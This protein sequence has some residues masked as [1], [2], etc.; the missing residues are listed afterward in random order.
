MLGRGCRHY[1]THTLRS[2]ARRCCKKGLPCIPW[3]SFQAF[4]HPTGRDRGH[5]TP[6]SVDWGSG[7]VCRV[8][9]AATRRGRHARSAAPGGTV[10]TLAGSRGGF[11]NGQGAAVRFNK[12]VGLAPDADGSV[13]WLRG[14]QA[15][16]EG[17]SAHARARRA[18]AA[19]ATHRRAPK[20]RARTGPRGGGPAP[21]HPRTGCNG[22][23]R[24]GAR[25]GEETLKR[26][27][28][29][30]LAARRSPGRWL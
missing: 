5:Y 7:E 23:G 27:R 17:A 4:G 20:R 29:R 19:A 25:S 14:G 13:R 6:R 9:V 26:T 1:Q 21:D 18:D 16:S 3:D 15:D 24:S 2:A 22:A 30:T 12:P 10:R 11:A 8:R 28:H